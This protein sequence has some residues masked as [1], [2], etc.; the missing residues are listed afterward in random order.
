LERVRPDGAIGTFAGPAVGRTKSLHE[1]LML[2]THSERPRELRWFHAGPMLYGDWGT[3]RFYVLGLAFYY[4]LH[5]SFWY[6]CGVCTLVAGVG[7]AYTIICKCYPDG[8]GVY[9]AARHTSKNLAVIGALLLFADY[10]VTASLS[11][12]DGMHYLGF[13]DLH[14]LFGLHLNLGFIHI[15]LDY[16]TVC[17]FAVL[18]IGAIG[19]INYIGPKK[20]GTF[21][22][23]VAVA[24][25]ILTVV[26]VIASVPHLAQ[27][28]K[29]IHLPREPLHDQWLNLV[30]VVLA[31]SGVEAIANMTG[32]MVPPVSRTSKKAIFPVLIEVVVFNI[33]LAIALN[34][35]MPEGPGDFLRPA[36]DYD[37]AISQFEKAHP[38]WEQT[39]ALKTEHDA[40]HAPSQREQDVENKALR[41]MAHDF[42]GPTF[43]G[44]CGIVFGLLLLSAV[45]TAVADMVSIQYVMSR[46]DELPRWFTKLNLFGVPWI[47]L[48]PA[49]LLPVVLLIVDH[50]LATLADLYAIGVV[51]AIT[52]NLGSCCYNKAMPLKKYERIGMGVLAVIMGAIELTLAYQKHAALYFAG[53]VLI[54][55]LI[56]RYISKA[57]PA[58][59]ARRKTA[60]ALQVVGPREETD[61]AATPLIAEADVNKRHI[62]VATR[63]APRLLEFATQYAKDVNALL[64]VLFVRQIN[65]AFT[66]DVRGPTFEEDREAQEVFALVKDYAAKAGVPIV[67]IYVVS[68]DVAYTIL[69]F[70]ATY[71]VSSLLMGVSRKATL[72]RALQGDT[73][74]AVADQLPNDIPLLIHA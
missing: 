2:A 48:L 38:G 9:S 43:A 32:I 11:A 15:G 47:A 46:D 56:L 31:L 4:A 61:L 58:A 5:A 8:G 29:N 35:L 17:L 70:A 67:P 73:L 71:N 12:L 1:S 65:V 27:G 53:S 28:W 59:Q 33:I 52:I 41:V 51:G 16:S 45:N 37:A 49:I 74:T 57:I 21:A 22:L 10:I 20:A 72:L 14:V 63:G 18:S 66:A 3:S 25:L 69:D 60:A 30:N 62:M 40:L 36:A 13:S 50:D 68:Q 42:V 64:F 34:A 44:I 39:P 23:V 7:W 6:V 26:L 24:T 54:V 55:G 19:I